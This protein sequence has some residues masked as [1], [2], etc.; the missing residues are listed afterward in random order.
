MPPCSVPV[1]LTASER[2]TLQRR[3][4]GATTPYR[5]R[6]RAQ[7]VL[8]AARGRPTARIAVDLGISEDTARRWRG[9]FATCRLDGREDLPPPRPPRRTPDPPPPAPR[10]PRPASPP[11]RRARQTRPLRAR[12]ATL[13]NKYDGV[14]LPDDA[15]R[16]LVIDGLP[17]A[18]SGIDRI[19]AAALDDTVAMM[20]RQLQRIEQGMGRGIRSRDDYC[21][22]MLLGA[23]LVRRLHDPGAIAHFST[24]TAAQLQLSRLAAEHLA[25]RDAD[26][27]PAPPYPCL[28]RNP[29]H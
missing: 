22:V 4:R 15:C 1:T 13:V 11:S 19:E 29:A 23:R 21:V 26:P 28:T 27:P 2:K 24:A 5:D 7:I 8:A 25:A 16:V 12:L 14:D 10:A 20:G 9:R 17:E 18:Y 3:A 6:V